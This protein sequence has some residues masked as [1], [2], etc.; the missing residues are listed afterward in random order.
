LVS[1]VLFFI[2]LNTYN[3]SKDYFLVFLGIGY[4]FVGVL[5]MVHIFIYPGVSIIFANGNQSIVVQFWIAARYLGILTLLGSTL[6]LYKPVKRLSSNLVFSIYF[7][8]CVSIILSILYFRIFPEC[9]IPGQGLTQFKIVSEYIFSAVLILLSLLYFNL[10]RNMDYKLFFYMECHLIIMAVSEVF[11]TSYISPYD[12]TNIWAHIL[13]VVAYFFLHKAIIETGIK[14][15]YSVL[16]HKM[17]EIDSKLKIA[18]D[19]LKIEKCQRRMMEEMFVRNDHCYELIINNSS[20]AIIVTSRGRFIF[21][22][23]RA[24]KIFGVDKPACLIGMDVFQFINPEKREYMKEFFS[25]AFANTKSFLKEE[26]SI[27]SHAGRTIDVE[28]T[29][30]YVL[31]HGKSSLMS[32]IK[33]VS[34]QKQINKLQNDIRDNE[35]RL[36]ETKEYN[37]L[38]MEFFSN[39]SHELKTPLSVMLGAIQVLSMPHNEEPPQSYE[40]KLDKYLEIMKQNCYRLLRLIS[41]LI[42]LSKFDSGY[43]KL[44]LKNYNIVNVIEDITMSV[45]DYVENR[46]L[47]IIFDTDVEEKEMA[48]DSDKIERIMLNLISNAVKF[49]DKGGQIFVNIKDMGDSVSISVRD[50]G[51]GIPKDKIDVIFDRFVQVDKTFAR[52]KEGS[53]I[54]LSLVKTLVEMHGGTIKV[55]SVEGQGSEFTIE[56]PVKTIDHE[57]VFDHSLPGL[58]NIEKVNVEFSDIYTYS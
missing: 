12:W 24:A 43:L 34:S 25:R 32:I 3:V 42:D 21:A 7:I 33:D 52:N 4:F 13:K 45:V 49:T 35:K 44:N 28:I 2:A 39:I 36:S 37:R 41:N 14:K 40:Q 9:Y 57:I 27:I 20:D 1:L 16:F 23:D 8:I 54:G 38:L 46:G 50:T 22:N 58:S 6:L 48:V 18:K 10:R 56:L 5:D 15:P 47:E 17:G 53:G 29:G 55:N 11:F 51:I 31:Y 26:F 30:G 19:R